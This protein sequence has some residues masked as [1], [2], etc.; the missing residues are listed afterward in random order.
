MDKLHGHSRLQDRNCSLAKTLALVEKVLEVNPEKRMTAQKLA[1]ELAHI[2]HLAEGELRTG[3]SLGL[4]AIAEVPSRS[5]TPIPTITTGYDPSTLPRPA[6][7]ESEALS[8][9]SVPD[10]P[11]GMTMPNR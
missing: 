3:N 10:P 1:D 8:T 2:S 5:P 7:E 11:S 6:I 4:A 9:P